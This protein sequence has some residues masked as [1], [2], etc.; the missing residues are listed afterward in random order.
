MTVRSS[1]ISN[2]CALFNE[3]NSKQL[4]SNVLERLVQR[5]MLLDCN[6]STDEILDSAVNAGL[7]ERSGSAYR[8]TDIGYRLG[9]KQG[10]TSPNTT[11]GAKSFLAKKIYLNPNAGPCFCSDI[12]LSLRVDTSLGTFVLDRD[13]NET[14]E[15]VDWLKTLSEIGLIEVD[16][17]MAKVV[18]THL[19]IV[20][21]AL[22][23][24][25]EKA[26]PDSDESAAERTKIGQIAETHAVQHEKRRLRR[27]GFPELASL[28]KQISIVD[29]SAGYDVQSFQGTGKHPDNEIFIEVKGTRKSEV[30]FIWSRNERR[31]ARKM[32]RKYWIYCFTRIDLQSESARGPHRIND[33]IVRLE[34]GSYLIESLA[35]SILMKSTA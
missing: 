5:C 12:L 21:E 35:V 33:P 25:R 20:N 31:V 13:E 3:L 10:T 15:Q 18:V 1:E 24:I 26:S 32:R 28:V 9:K 6:A 11:D 23:W 4:A 2:V 14:R 7:I 8:L 27:Y 19:G 29:R 17:D 22:R 16:A 34:Q 30:Q